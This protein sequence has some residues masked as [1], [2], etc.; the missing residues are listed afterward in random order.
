M[1]TIFYFFISLHCRVLT[2]LRVCVCVCVCVRNSPLLIINLRDD[3]VVAEANNNNVI[4]E[5]FQCI[6]LVILF[7]PKLLR[8]RL[9]NGHQ[10]SNT[11]YLL[12]EL[13]LLCVLFPPEKREFH[14]N[15][16]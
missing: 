8:I 9:L 6:K 15:N 12:R 1:T 7:N 10:Y 5:V 2:I 13:L 3:N 11:K 14:H 4:L 16:K